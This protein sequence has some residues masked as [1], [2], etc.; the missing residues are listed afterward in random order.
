MHL[1]RL[2]ILSAALWLTACDVDLYRPVRVSQLP[3]AIRSYVEQTYP[4]SEIRWA[5]RDDDG[6]E[7]KL[8]NGRE[9]EFDLDGVFLRESD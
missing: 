6:Y 5:K 2:L 8:S 7:I 9:L 4:G 3:E 1:L